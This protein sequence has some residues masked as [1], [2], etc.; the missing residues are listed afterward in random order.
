ML[1]PRGMEVI[2]AKH[3]FEWLS[4]CDVTSPIFVQH[5]KKVS[6]SDIYIS[7]L[8][9]MKLFFFDSVCSLKF[10]KN[11]FVETASKENMLTEAWIETDA[12]SDS[13][14]KAMK[15]WTWTFDSVITEVTDERPE[16]NHATDELR[17]LTTLSS[18]SIF[19]FIAKCR[20]IE[21]VIEV[22]FLKH[23]TNTCSRN[24]MLTNR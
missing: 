2:G 1:W 8:C 18:A 19:T 21:T 6:L 20:T 13:A 9:W 12:N 14:S 4:W 11:K 3:Y 7:I 23:R 17:L 5:I 22:L 16:N 10:I 15:H 24:K